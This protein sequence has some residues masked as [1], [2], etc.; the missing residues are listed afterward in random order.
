M[1][2]IKKIVTLLLVLAMTLATTA[3][4]LAADSTQDAGKGTIT[5]QN[6][7]ADKEYKAYK[8]F[9]KG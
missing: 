5:V 2:R 8:I 7:V 3:T 6:A 1:K 4:V 9:Y